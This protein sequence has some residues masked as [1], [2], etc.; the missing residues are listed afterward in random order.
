MTNLDI[1]QMTKAD[2]RTLL[3]AAA[4]THGETWNLKKKH[5]NVWAKT[6]ADRYRNFGF[7]LHV[8]SKKGRPPKWY[9]K[10]NLLD[11]KDEEQ[12]EEEEEDEEEDEDEEEAATG[13]EDKEEAQSGEADEPLKKTCSSQCRIKKT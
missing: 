5:H 6:V 4:Q 9:R 8:Q 13:E 11:D 7:H 3:K 2:A 12:D 1:L 10:L